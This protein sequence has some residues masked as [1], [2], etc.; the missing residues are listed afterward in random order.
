MIFLVSLRQL[1]GSTFSRVKETKYSIIT[2]CCKHIPVGP[3]SKRN[4]VD[5]IWMFK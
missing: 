3:W 4:A 1:T 5:I 2:D